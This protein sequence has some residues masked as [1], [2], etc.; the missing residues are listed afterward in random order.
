MKGRLSLGVCIP[1][2]KRPDQLLECVRSVAASAKGFPVTIFITDDSEDDTNREAIE[3]IRALHPKV[4]YEKNRKNLGIDRNILRSV[5]LCTC[6]YAWLLGEDDRMLPDA[7]GT[8]MGVL[9]EKAPGTPFVYVN[10]MAV[11]DEVKVIL[12]PRSVTMKEDRISSA[13]DFLEEEGWSMGFLGACVVRKSCWQE[14]RQDRYLGTYFAH[15]G[16]IL[17][18]LRDKRLFMVA[19]PLILNR[20]ATPKTFTWVN[21]YLEV[22]DG[23]S[24]LMDLLEPLYGRESCQRSLMSFEKGH[25]LNTIRFL[26]YLRAD[27]VYDRGIYEQYVR[28]KSGRPWYKLMARIVARTDPRIFRALRG[29]RSSWRKR[30]GGKL[31]NQTDAASP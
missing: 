25:G 24:R 14:A 10:Y 6:D 7:V 28:P 4:V 31:S 9:E 5:D 23:W 26:C 30:A 13:R 3:K 12:K 11:D 29:L 2:Y 16:V 1:T 20:C 27:G 22:L 15:A 8:L 17:E 18:C 21:Q 19:R